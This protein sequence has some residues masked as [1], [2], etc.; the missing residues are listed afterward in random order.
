V[1]LEY[2]RERKS[3]SRYKNILWQ[4]SGLTNVSMVLFAYQKKNI[5]STIEAAMKYLGQTALSDRLAFVDAEDWKQSPAH[6]PITL[7]T[8]VIKL[9]VACRRFEEKKAA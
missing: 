4:Y 1:A 2:E 5:K 7:K 3:F 9:A 8:G 6:A